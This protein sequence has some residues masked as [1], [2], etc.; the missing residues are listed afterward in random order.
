MIEFRFTDL[1]AEGSPA[2][3]AD[4]LVRVTADLAVVVDGRVVYSEVDFPVVELAAA[5]VRWCELPAGGRVDFEF[6]SMS[7]P[8]PGWVWIRREGSGWRVGSL[9]EEYPAMLESTA[10]QICEA[11]RRLAVRLVATGRGS[12]GV[13]LSEWVPTLASRSDLIFHPDLED[14]R[15]RCR[16]CGWLHRDPPWGV[17]GISPLF[18]YCPCCGMEHG[19]QD[20]TPAGARRYRAEWRAGGAEFSERDEQ[21]CCWDLEDQL[22]HVP[23]D[24]L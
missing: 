16:V 22:S 17:D 18:D 6:D 4:A 5:L 3:L 1:R 13:D 10:D 2:S 23:G 7:T 19:Y 21:P 24:F 9:H 12:L 14:D 8:E 20:A 11:V 15:H